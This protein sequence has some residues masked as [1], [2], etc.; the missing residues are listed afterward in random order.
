MVVNFY[1]LRL[2]KR[3][4]HVNMAFEHP[5]AS[6]GVFLYQV[7]LRVGREA[8]KDTERLR[9]ADCSSWA[10]LRV[11]RKDVRIKKGM[12]LLCNLLT[13]I[14]HKRLAGNT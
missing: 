6:A 1:T 4:D 7:K 11:D 12:A 13:G 3:S 2:E 10:N 14:G 8:P 5:G 9:K